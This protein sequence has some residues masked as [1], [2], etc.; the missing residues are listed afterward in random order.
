MTLKS[1]LLGF[2]AIVALL[3]SCKKEV[4][5]EDGKISGELET[6][7]KFS[8]DGTQYNGDMDSAFIQTAAG[9]T[10]LSM[11]GSGTTSQPGELV[12]QIVGETIGEAQYGAEQAAF[13]YS[14][15]GEIV[16]Q[17]VPGQSGD[18]SVTITELDSTHVSGTFSGVAYDTTGQQHTIAEGQFTAPRSS[19]TDTDPD[20][21]PTQTGQLT[22]WAEQRCSDGS[23]IEVL[24]NGQKGFIT[25][26]TPEE[27]ECGD[28]R[29]ATFTLP[30][31]VYT[32]QAICGSDTVS[33]TVTLNSS[34]VKFKVAFDEEI[35]GDYLPL[36]IGSTWKYVDLGNPTYSHTVTAGDF[37]DIDGRQYWPQGSDNLEDTFYYRKNGHEYYEWL[38]IDYNGSVANPPSVELIIL[39][40][41]FSEGQSWQSPDIFLGELSGIPN[42]Y[43]KLESTIVLKG[44]ITVNGVEYP[45]AIQVETKLLFSLDGGTSYV[46]TGSSFT[47]VFAKG[48]GIV[49]YLDVDAGILYAATEINI[50]P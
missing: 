39:H 27:P 50:V 24:V 31:G 29:T 20:P 35:T 22:I 38:T 47:R 15:N 9:F 19:F 14:V 12:I 44:A 16:Y 41:D 17:K 13:Q 34:C 21:D 28:P 5:V 8:S 1:S 33:Y 3:F 6:T 4:S 37:V 45:D 7:W 23:S 26:E 40:D 49:S 10:V 2:L 48:K 30:Q 46:D 32:V 42:V 11:V 18:F 36:T 25:E 43:A